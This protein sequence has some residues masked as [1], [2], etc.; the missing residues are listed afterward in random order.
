MCNRTKKSR[1]VAPRDSWY[2]SDEK[3][4]GI[5]VASRGLAC[6]SY[7][8]RRLAAALGAGARPTDHIV[9]PLIEAFSRP[10]AHISQCFRG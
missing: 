9:C 2:G 8:V 1:N 7:L 6:G 4:D 5:A 3:G 10:I